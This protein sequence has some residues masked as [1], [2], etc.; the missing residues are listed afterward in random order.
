M[1]YTTSESEWCISER[2]LSIALNRLCPTLNYYT[3]VSD[4]DL[5][6]AIGK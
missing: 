1:V 5:R 2:F 4:D 3:A 6:K